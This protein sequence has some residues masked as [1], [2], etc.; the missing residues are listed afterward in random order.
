VA[1][2]Q[3]V[4]REPSICLCGFKTIDGYLAAVRF[5]VGLFEFIEE[6]LALGVFGSAVFTEE[7]GGG[8]CAGEGMEGLWSVAIVGFGI[9][10]EQFSPTFLQHHDPNVFTLCGLGE[11]GFVF[12]IYGEEVVDDDFLV[13]AVEGELADIVAVVVVGFGDKDVVDAIVLLC[14][15]GK[16]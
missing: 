4:L 7:V 14:E 5:F 2:R 8:G 15:C 16:G 11:D 9:P 12:D 10:F 1:G 3:T 13:D 6:D